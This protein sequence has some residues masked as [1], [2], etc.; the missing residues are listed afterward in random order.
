M[1]CV[2]QRGGLRRSPEAAD[3]SRRFPPR[4]TQDFTQHLIELRRRIISI[5]VVFGAVTIL[6]YPLA[7]PIL[8]KAKSDLLG[9][10]SLVILEPQEAVVAY[11]NVSMLIGLLLT[12]P[13]ITYHMWAFMAPGL[14][15][16]EKKMVAYLVVPSVLMFLAGVAFGYFILLPL[17][18]RI[19]LSSA[20]PLATP[21]LSLGSVISFSV[22]ILAA[23]GLL[24][25]MPLVSAALS[26]LGVLKASTLSKYRRHA[27]VLIVLVAGII[28]P[29]PTIIP[30]LILSVPMIL[31][32]EL[33]IWTSRLAGGG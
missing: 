9:G 14:L 25:Q 6:S 24:F 21:M 33:S 31:L 4:F 22:T 15:A 3:F 5:L 7:Q 32:F 12:L 2:A 11:V 1:A 29:D 26:K 8:L 18:F 13:L 30:Q 20:E 23:L 27:I 16:K 10:V 17:A 28:T 19:L